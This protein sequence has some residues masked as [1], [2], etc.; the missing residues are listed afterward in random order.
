MIT[1]D[2][3]EGLLGTKCFYVY[4]E[5]TALSATI[6]F[7]IKSGAVSAPVASPPPVVSD[8]SMMIPVGA[9]PQSLLHPVPNKESKFSKSC[10]CQRERVEFT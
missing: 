2:S 8:D 9:S 1:S 3:G 5:T 4:W 10:T 6:A 7:P